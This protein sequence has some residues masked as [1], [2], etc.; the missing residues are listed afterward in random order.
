M[1][2]CVRVSECQSVREA[3]KR[4][5]KKEKEAEIREKREDREKI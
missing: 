5:V 4:K 2:K 1:K 3:V